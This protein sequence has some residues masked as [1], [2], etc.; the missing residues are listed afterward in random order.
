MKKLITLLMLV[1]TALTSNAGFRHIWLHGQV[2]GDAEWASYKLE[3]SDGIKYTLTKDNW[4]SG[5]FGFKETNDETGT[6]QIKWYNADGA[7]S[8]SESNLSGLKIKEGG[9]NF[10]SS[11]TGK[12]TLELNINTNTFSIIP[13]VSYKLSGDLFSATK[14]TTSE[15]DLNKVGEKYCIS[16]PM[17]F[18]ADRTFVV[19]KYENGV[20]KTIWGAGDAEVEITA[21]GDQTISEGKTANFKNNLVGDYTLSFDPTNGKITITDAGY[22]YVLRGTMFGDK[23]FTSY[24]LTK[25]S[26]G[27]YKLSDA[28]AQRNWVSGADKYFGIAKIDGDNEINWYG[29]GTGS[30][31]VNISDT[32]GTINFNAQPNSSKAFT[33]NLTSKY[34]FSFDPGTLAI[35]MTKIEETIMPIVI[36]EGQIIAIRGT[37]FGDADWVSYPMTPNGDGTWSIRSRAW[38]ANTEFGLKV[39][40]KAD[41]SDEVKWVAALDAGN[42]TINT[43]KLSVYA[44]A[45]SPTNFKNNLNG[46]YGMTFNPSE[47]SLTFSSYEGV[48][49]YS[50]C[51]FTSDENKFT[52]EALTPNGDGT[53]SMTKKFAPCGFFISETYNDNNNVLKLLNKNTNLGGDVTTANGPFAFDLSGYAHE[54]NSNKKYLGISHRGEF[55]IT[56]NPAQHKLT[57][58]NIGYQL[59]GTV[60]GTQ[61][62]TP[63]KFRNDYTYEYP[64]AVWTPGEFSIQKTINGTVSETYKPTTPI[65][66][67]LA[68]QTVTMDASGSSDY[69]EVDGRE[70]RGYWMPDAKSFLI[71]IA[72]ETGNI[73]SGVEDL[74]GSEGEVEYYTLQGVKVSKENLSAGMYIVKKGGKTAKVMVK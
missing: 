35:T 41:G 44:K 36:E 32:N 5:D 1:V 47:M 57:V 10:S 8:I 56:Y 53:Y 69:S 31:A 38:K 23:E 45:S 66:A 12:Y 27:L 52:P 55:E 18:F 26:N 74:L 42:Q 11:L 49:T 67:N 73:G 19:K 15:V 63:L 17:W 21:A 4:T 16:A 29:A 9:T 22:S 59:A 14:G 30:D 39:C 37:M 20:E 24:Q 2:F 6:N 7:N 50:L 33:S 65:A 34:N 54:I 71:F 40:T 72:D 70:V 58:S 61:P 25:Q 64:K 60:D 46:T 13:P 48:T 3:T 51:T 28:D 43:D 68:E 62:T